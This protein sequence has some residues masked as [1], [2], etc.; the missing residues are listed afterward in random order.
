MTATGETVVTGA[1]S[2]T[3]TFGTFP[4]TTANSDIFITR[5]TPGV[6]PIHD[7]AVKLGGTAFD[8]VQGLALDSQGTVN[9][10]S[11]WSGMTDVAG[12]PLT[13]Q[14]YDGWVGQFVR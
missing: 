12:T 14:D 8:D 3:I 1:F 5:M 13:S 4:L 6:T 7:W 11:A 2:N 10:I 9:V